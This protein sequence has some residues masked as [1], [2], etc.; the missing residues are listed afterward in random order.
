[1]V[2]CTRLGGG[3][4]KEG[5]KVIS[6]NIKGTRKT[7]SKKNNFLKRLVELIKNHKII[8][9]SIL[10][11]VIILIITLYIVNYI[12]YQTKIITINKIDYTKSDFAIYLYSAKYNYF[13]NDAEITEDDLKVIVDEENKKTVSDQLKETALNDIKT[14]SAIRELA[15]K[16]NITLSDSDYDEL[17]SEKKEFIK[18]LGGNRKF[19]KFLGDN[20]TNEEAYDKMSETDKLYKKTLENIFSE[21]KINDL[22]EEEIEEA[23][24]N[25]SS[26]YLQ[27]KQVILTI[28]DI[29]SGKSLSSTTINQKETLAKN[30]VEEANNGTNF[31][32][33]I[34][35]YSEDAIDKEPPYDLYYKS[36]ELLSE[37]ESA[38]LEL[39]PGEVSKP[40]KTKYA[41]H[42]IQRQALDESKL[43][44]YYDDLREDKCIDEL[45]SYLEDLQIVY[46]DAYDKLKI[47]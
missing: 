40:I 39:K 17:D 42:V 10:A 46:H 36:G 30:I 33:L 12:S 5:K 21:G 3:I 26:K 35:K 14:A 6:K 16:Y 18:Q 31:D 41:Y 44:D 23:N 45:K 1:M 34:Q 19:K 9:I 27:I 43:D 38:I 37:L 20:N 47:K 24:T 28:I 8:S 7:L 2:V 29:D 13:G 11:L 15:N 4:M 22:T 25:Y 32:D